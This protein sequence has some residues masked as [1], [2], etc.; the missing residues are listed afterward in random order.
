[1]TPMDQVDFKTVSVR[2]VE[3]YLWCHRWRWWSRWLV[4]GLEQNEVEG[5][6]CSLRSFVTP[7]K[8]HESK[9]RLAGRRAS[10]QVEGKNSNTDAARRV[11]YNITTQRKSSSLEGFARSG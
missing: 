4:E 11:Y 1:M 6:K 2:G 7:A 8:D 9:S 10:K 3:Q 5:D